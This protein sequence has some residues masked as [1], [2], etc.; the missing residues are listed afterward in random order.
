MSRTFVSIIVATYN[1]RPFMKH[2][3]HMFKSQKYPQNSMEMIVIDDGEDNISDLFQ[4]KPDNIRYYRLKRKIM[5]SD[6][7]NLLNK[8]AKGDIIISWDDDDYYSPDYVKVVVTRLISNPNILLAGKTCMDTYFVNTGEIYRVGPYHQNHCTNTSLCYKREYLNQGHMYESGKD[9]AEEKYFLDSYKNPMI[10]LNNENMHIALSHDLN[11]FNR[12]KQ[13]EFNTSYKK[14]NM[15]LK[16][17]IKDKKS[18]EF[19]KNSKQ[20]II[21][22]QDYLDK[23]S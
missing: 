3:L 17:I 2:V 22:Y 16:N 12:E 8:A 15:K 18:L 11:T 4:N 23:L 19:F 9:H 21:E 5:L 1:R 20:M 6:K 7:R 13:K 10:Q 14:T